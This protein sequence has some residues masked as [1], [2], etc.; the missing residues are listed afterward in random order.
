MKRMGKR[1]GQTI[2]FLKWIKRYPGWWYLICTPNDGHMNISMMNMLI[3]RLAQ[4][5]FYEIIFVLLMV[6]RGEGFMKNIPGF[7]LLEMVTKNWGSKMNGK[8]E[9]LKDIL[10]FL[11]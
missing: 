11:E 9:M 2:R 5:R 3:K 7:M 10:S 1:D 8:E 4:E 6:H